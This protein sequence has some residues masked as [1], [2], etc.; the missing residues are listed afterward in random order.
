MFGRQNLRK[1]FL[2]LTN[3]YESNTVKQVILSKQRSMS[4]YENLN[5]KE[6]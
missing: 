2:F 5:I 3:L 4:K 6:I 1:S